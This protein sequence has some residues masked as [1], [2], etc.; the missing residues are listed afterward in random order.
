RRSMREE[1]PLG[2]ASGPLP[3]SIRTAWAAETERAE[4]PGRHSAR[5]SRGGQALEA[6]RGAEA[7][8]KFREHGAHLHFGL[9]IP[10]SQRLGRRA[11]DAGLGASALRPASPGSRS[12]FPS[13]RWRRGT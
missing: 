1:A 5:G 6:E 11:L 7:G 12:K 13:L 2:D 3:G 9:A 4:R 8:L 10:A